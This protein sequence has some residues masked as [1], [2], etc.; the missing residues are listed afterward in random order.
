MLLKTRSLGPDLLIAPFVHLA[1]RHCH[2]PEQASWLLDDRADNVRADNVRAH[3]VRAHTLSLHCTEMDAC[4]LDCV[5]SQLTGKLILLFKVW[6]LPK[7]DILLQTRQ[8]HFR[9]WEKIGYLTFENY[10]FGLS[11]EPAWSSD[12]R[13][14]EDDFFVVK[15]LCTFFIAFSDLFQEDD[16]FKTLCT[17]AF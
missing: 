16:F 7:Y 5:T 9:K 1:L 10:C 8:S 2:P 4:A 11:F 17:F 15:T 12:D 3:N 13:F 14:Q 6:H